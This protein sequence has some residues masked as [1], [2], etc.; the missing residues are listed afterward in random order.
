VGSTGHSTGPHLHF[1]VRERNGPV[2]PL[3]ALS[4][5]LAF[6]RR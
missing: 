5:G 3:S 4:N 1:E 6:A 2:N